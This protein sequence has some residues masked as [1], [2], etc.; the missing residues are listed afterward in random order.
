R[1]WERLILLHEVRKEKIKVSN[2]DIV[3]TISEYPFFQKDGKF[4]N[5]IYQQVLLYGL[6]I[7]TSDF[8]RHIR[9]SL[10]IEGLLKEKTK[11]VTVNDADLMREFKKENEEIK[12]AYVTFNNEAFKKGINISDSEANNY[13]KTNKGDFY[14]QSQINIEY[15]GITIDQEENQEKK[16][17]KREL[18]LSILE[19][20]KES[21]LLSL[22]K[23]HS[24]SYNKTGL[25]SIDQPIPDIGW[26]L[27]FLNAISSLKPGEISEVIETT[28]GYYI[29]ELIEIKEP[30]LPE[31]QEAKDKVMDVLKI[32]QS[33][34]LALKKAYEIKDLLEKK[35]EENPKLEFKRLINDLDLDLLQTPFFKHGGYLENIGIS[36][37]FSKA[38]FSLADS[39]KRLAIASSPKASY[40]IRLVEFKGADEKKFK[41]EEYHDRLIAQKEQE[42]F[43]NFLQELKQRAKLKTN[44]SSSKKLIQQ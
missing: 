12:V 23:E 42:S 15:I 3:K 25:F 24:L 27:E 21:D 26:S 16:T 43:Y 11:K 8:E 31:F 22:S 6:R 19:Q 17:Q 7:K 38:A 4:N 35:L 39:P 28:Q 2:E 10:E 37:E 36:D 41:K 5:E 1:T 33:K 44:L 14:T 18:M 32:R 29:A 13:F 20:T 40:V 34:E 30:Y 9:E